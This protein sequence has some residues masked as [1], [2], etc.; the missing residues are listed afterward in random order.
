MKP[1]EFG[2]LRKLEHIPEGE[3]QMRQLGQALARGK[4]RARSG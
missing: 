1:R 4:R 3:R 2:P